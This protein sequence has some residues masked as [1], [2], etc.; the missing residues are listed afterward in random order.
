M[1]KMLALPLAV[2][3]LA[4]VIGIANTNTAPAASAKAESAAASTGDWMPHNYV[5]SGYEIPTEIGR[6]SCRERV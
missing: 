6:A 1:K 2:C 4:P 5:L 3:M